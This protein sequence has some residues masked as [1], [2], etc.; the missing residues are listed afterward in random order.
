MREEYNELGKVGGLTVENSM[1]QGAN[2]LMELQ[3]IKDHPEQM[4]NSI[5]EEFRQGL[6]ALYINQND[7]SFW[8][9]PVA[10]EQY[11]A[12]AETSDDV[13]NMFAVQQLHYKSLQQ[14]TKQL[15]KMQTQLNALTST[16]QNQN[17]QQNNKIENQ[18]IINPKTGQPYKRCC[19][20]CGCCPW[21]KNCLRKAKGHKDEATFKNRMGGTTK[22]V[23]DG[24]G[25][26]KLICLFVIII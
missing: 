26:Q 17:F 12:P 7:Q 8:Q 22:T 16:N 4:V 15:Q 5:K 20:T 18:N 14:L 3:D 23:S 25:A 2:L 6:Q 13:N 11:N 24:Q 9:P 19:W 10:E 1:L 21:S